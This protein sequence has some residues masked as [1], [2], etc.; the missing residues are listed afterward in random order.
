MG[1]GRRAWLAVAGKSAGRFAARKALGPKAFDRLS[2]R[3]PSTTTRDGTRMPAPA[4]AAL[5]AV[6]QSAHRTT[7][8]GGTSMP[9]PARMRRT[10]S[11]ATA[12]GIAAAA[13]AGTSRRTSSRRS[14]TRTARGTRGGRGMTIAGGG[15]LADFAGAGTGALT[16]NINHAR[17]GGRRQRRSKKSAAAPPSKPPSRKQQVGRHA[18]N[19]L[20]GGAGPG[21]GPG[22]SSETASGNMEAAAAR[23]FGYGGRR[24]DSSIEHRRPRFF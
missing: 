1:S 3:D 14:S 8:L 24:D 13:G 5:R 15:R 17:G 21:G 6:G 9:M 10:G 4:T 20:L 16:I 12:D 11:S 7:S 22:G 2:G 19:I 18:F 23:L